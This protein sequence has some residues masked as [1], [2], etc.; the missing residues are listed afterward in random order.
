MADYVVI[1]H[2]KCGYAISTARDSGIV[3]DYAFTFW[4]AKRKAH[5][6]KKEDI[7][8]KEYRG[9]IPIYTTK[10]ESLNER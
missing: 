1:R 8:R 10:E 6:L 9:K 7:L 3:V 5:R 4:G 2:S